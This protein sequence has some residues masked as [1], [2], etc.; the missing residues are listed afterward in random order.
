MTGL[1]KLS[2]KLCKWK[3]QIMEDICKEGNIN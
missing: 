2:E 1:C 3:I